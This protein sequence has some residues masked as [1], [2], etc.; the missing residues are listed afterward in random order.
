LRE[1]SVAVNICDGG[2][3]VKHNAQGG[4]QTCNPAT[5]RPEAPHFYVL[6]TVANLII[7][8]KYMGSLS[9]FSCFSDLLNSGKC[10][11]VLKARNPLEARIQQKLQIRAIVIMSRIASRD[12]KRTHTAISEVGFENVTPTFARLKAGMRFKPFVVVIC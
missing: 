5:L 12:D 4:I 1:G 3:K 8:H 6:D 9:S 11:L 2:N 10:S 7:S